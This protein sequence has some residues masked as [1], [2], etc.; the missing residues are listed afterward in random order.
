MFI[1]FWN[2][3]DAIRAAGTKLQQAAA[4]IAGAAQEEEGI[5]V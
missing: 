5:H 1:L 2:A 4:S 3:Q